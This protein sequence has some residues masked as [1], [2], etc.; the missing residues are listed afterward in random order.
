MFA[1]VSNALGRPGTTARIAAFGAILMPTAFLIG[2]R[3]GAIGLAWGWLAAFPLL[4]AVT[5][6]LAGKPMG[7]RFADLI[8]AAAPGL[9]CSLL[10]AGA[11][12]LL[13]R[14]LPPLPAILRLGV[15]VPTGGI[16]FMGALMLCARASLV[17]LMQLVIKRAPPAAAPA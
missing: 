11:V 14:M 5:V 9:G 2:V 3:F 4:T 17:E 12:M 13:D 6:W 8:R 15:L 10:M 1:P 7:L 16:A